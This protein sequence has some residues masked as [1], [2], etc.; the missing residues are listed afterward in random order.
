MTNA[1]TA[2]GAGV[3]L[4]VYPTDSTA[5][6]TLADGGQGVDWVVLNQSD[7]PG[8]TADP[9]VTAAGAAV[10]AAG[11]TV[12]GYINYAYGSTPDATSTAQMTTWKGRGI[13]GVFLDE[14]PASQTAVSGQTATLAT[15]TA[16]IAALREAGAATVVLNPGTVPD[17][18]YIPLA[19]CTVIFQGS[20]A[21]WLAWTPPAWLQQWP[22]HRYAVLVYGV[23]S[24]P[25]EYQAYDNPLYT[26]TATVQEAAG[27]TAGFSAAEQVIADCA[28]Y[29]IRT[30]Y[31]YDKTVAW[32][33]LPAYWAQF[34]AQLG[35]DHPEV[36]T[37]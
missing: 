15:T 5:W 36:Y 17:P 11:T 7:G 9:V 18:A 22:P 10:T 2:M 37:Q 35:R 8:A 21:Q 23:A 32:D 30:V 26:D 33:G 6:A 29:G 13:S 27:T 24:G 28:R 14:A 1:P 4:Y 34:A 19:D 16:S 25:Q 20:Y 31:C 3:P 12:L